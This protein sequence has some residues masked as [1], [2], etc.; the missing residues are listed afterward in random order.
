MTKS[1][2]ISND[3]IFKRPLVKVEEAVV[4][5]VVAEVEG[6]VEVNFFSP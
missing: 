4:A 3:T 6:D 2:H 1:V 5:E